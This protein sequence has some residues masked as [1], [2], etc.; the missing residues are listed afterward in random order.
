MLLEIAIGDA[1]AVAWEFVPEALYPRHTWDGYQQ[2]PKTSNRK[3]PDRGAYTDDTLRSLANARVLLAEEALDPLSYIREIKRVFRED[4]RMGWSKNFQAFLEGQLEKPDTAWLHEMK[5]RDT[6]GA[7]MGAAVMGLLPTA[8]QA[9]EAGRIQALVTHDAVGAE[10]AAAISLA[11]FGMR[12]GA[13][14]GN[15]A[16]LYVYDRMPA[17]VHDI[18]EVGRV[19]RVD[20][21]A[22][23][24]AAAVFQVLRNRKSLKGIMD[25][26]LAMGGDTDSVAAAAFGMASLAPDAYDL[27][28]PTWAFRDLEA[29]AEGPETVS[30]I[31]Q[32]DIALSRLVAHL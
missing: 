31:R 19:G 29:M 10:Y 1:Y 24:T 16:L 21:S 22:R 20:M 6:N 27:R 26:V 11:A 32:T 30:R 4:R 17:V 14:R 12:T 28:L 2:R 9:E 25:E 5:G 15:D 7:L 13:C 23:T 18:H 3:P 8:D